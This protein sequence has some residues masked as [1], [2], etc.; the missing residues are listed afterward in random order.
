MKK[1]EVK[2]L[3]TLLKKLTQKEAVF[4]MLAN[5]AEPSVTDLQMAGIRDPRRVINRLRT[6]HE[7]PIYLNDR[8]ER[9]SGSVVRRYRLNHNQMP[10]GFGAQ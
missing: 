7:L 4:E 1:T 5:G 8:K 6:E 3:Q 2:K 10:A 9:S